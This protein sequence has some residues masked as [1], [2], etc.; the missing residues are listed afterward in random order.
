MDNI[1]ELK[2]KSIKKDLIFLILFTLLLIDKTSAVYESHMRVSLNM[3]LFI[4][5]LF[6]V[7][8]YT[9]EIVTKIK[10]NK[11]LQKNNIN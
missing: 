7:I 6:G 4:V 8:F 11:E 5:D 3:F 10:F 2:S 9:K 1:E